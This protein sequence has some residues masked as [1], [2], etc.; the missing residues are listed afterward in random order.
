MDISKIL[1]LFWLS[2]LTDFPF[3]SRGLNCAQPWFLNL[4]LLS[5]PMFLYKFGHGAITKVQK[6]GKQQKPEI[7]VSAGRTPLICPLA[8]IT[9]ILY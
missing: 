2:F 8:S 3:L 6:L 4:Y 7:K 1:T 9:S 5:C